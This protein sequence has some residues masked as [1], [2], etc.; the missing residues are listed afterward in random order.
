MALANYKVNQKEEL[1]GQAASEISITSHPTQ[2][3]ILLF[4]FLKT[5]GYIDFVMIF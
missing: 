4:L 3:Y 5:G 2:D 1:F